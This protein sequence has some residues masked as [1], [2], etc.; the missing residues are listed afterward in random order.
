MQMWKMFRMEATTR[1]PCS[2]CAGAT[3]L[4]RQAILI[5]AVSLG[6]L[7]M[8]CSTL[9]PRYGER[10]LDFDGYGW[11]AIDSEGAIGPGPNRFSAANVRLDDSGRLVLSTRRDASGW[12]CAEVFLDKSLSYGRYELRLLPIEGGLDPQVVFGFYTWDESAAFAHREIDIEIARWGRSTHPNLN[13]A[14]QPSEGHDE[15]VAVSEIDLSSPVT[16]RFDWSPGSLRFIVLDE[17]R[18]TEWS[19]PSPSPSDTVASRAMPEGGEGP[20]PPFLVPPDGNEVVSL[21][22]WLFQGR[23]PEKPTR[24]VVSGFSY[25]PLSN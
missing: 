7:L 5:L 11:K 10:H 9:V 13:F 15:R 20:P 12:S 18:R 4:S 22:L 17:G 14:V 8:S 1:S 2:L 19:F 25:T 23:S 21:N 16:M 6:S 3:N 24:V